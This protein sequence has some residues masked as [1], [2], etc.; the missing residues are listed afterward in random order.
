MVSGRKSV[1][2]LEPSRPATKN[3]AIS[4]LRILSYVNNIGALGAKKR[5][6]GLN[7]AAKRTGAG[8]VSKRCR[9]KRTNFKDRL[10]SILAI[11]ESE[12]HCPTCKLG[13][14]PGACVFAVPLVNLAAFQDAVS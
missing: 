11:N 9:A 8:P 6:S 5:H 2:R 1:T 4:D 12:E 10:L 3:V 7:H 14:E 13:S